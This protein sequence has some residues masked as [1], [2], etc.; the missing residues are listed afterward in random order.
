MLLSCFRRR[1]AHTEGRRNPFLGFHDLQQNDPN[2]CD[3]WAIATHDRATGKGLH[4]QSIGGC[5]LRRDHHPARW[6]ATMARSSSP[7]CPVA[8]STMEISVWS[9][10]RYD[11]RCEACS[12]ADRSENSAGS[13]C[14]HSARRPDQRITCLA[15]ILQLTPDVHF[16][17]I[18]PAL[19]I[20]SLAG[21]RGI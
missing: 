8:V 19:A 20:V 18:M 21:I 12:V 11:R 2:R 15:A 17:T 6:R 10:S 16:P 9:D 14:A 4:C 5:N 3:S 1:A 7:T 13:W